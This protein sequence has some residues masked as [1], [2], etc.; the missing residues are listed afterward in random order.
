MTF[1]QDK[2]GTYTWFRCGMFLVSLSLDSRLAV[3]P[4]ATFGLDPDG[5]YKLGGDPQI[6]ESSPTG[7]AVYQ[8]YEKH[9]EPMIWESLKSGNPSEQAIAVQHMG[10]AVMVLNER[11]S[12]TEDR[13]A[14]LAWTTRNNS[15]MCNNGSRS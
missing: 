3:A 14:V 9:V 13:H 8:Y 4:V 2:E 6:H 10:P 5:Y 15:A 7:K 11:T 1:R 12:I